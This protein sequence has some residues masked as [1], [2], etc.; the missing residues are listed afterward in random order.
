MKIFVIDTVNGRV[1][2]AVADKDVLFMANVLELSKT[3]NTYYVDGMNV[4]N[5][6]TVFGAGGYEKWISPINN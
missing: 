2:V 3:V 4:K 5:Q 6:Q 1:E